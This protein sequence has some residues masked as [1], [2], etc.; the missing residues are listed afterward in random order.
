M[1]KVTDGPD[2]KYFLQ[3]K[4]GINTAA[5]IVFQQYIYHNQLPRNH[6]V[7]RNL[8]YPG[9]RCHT[10]IGRIGNCQTGC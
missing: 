4:K 5:P 9:H 3:P 8:R 10:C 2:F 1:I 7:L 6:E